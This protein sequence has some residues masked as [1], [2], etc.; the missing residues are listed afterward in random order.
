[1]TEHTKNM[2][3]AAA[4]SLL[5]VGGWDY[6]VAFPQLDKQRVNVAE[7]QR[8]AKLQKPVNGPA[9]EVARPALKL[10]RDGALAAGAR[11]PIDT[12][13]IS[14]SIA[15]KGARIDDVSLK[16][17]HETVDNSS[18]IIVLLSPEEAPTPYFA[19][20]G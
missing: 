18:P 17:Y 20:L 14:G 9:G 4:L 10:T 2:L 12:R 15:L 19:E 16:N 5:F 7:Q 1:M 13:S 8:I 11:L 3:I 6:F